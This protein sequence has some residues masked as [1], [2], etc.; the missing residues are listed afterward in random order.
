MEDSL[1]TLRVV[2]A[3]IETAGHSPRG[4][5]LSPSTSGDSFGKAL[6][7]QAMRLKSAMLN[8]K[9]LLSVIQIK[10]LQTP[11]CIVGGKSLC[12]FTCSDMFKCGKG[13]YSLFLWHCFSGQLH[14]RCKASRACKGRQGRA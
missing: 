7:H 12:N 6:M 10:W 5:T 11:P 13:L 1:P 3:E 8:Q 14:G 2:A 9:V 4:D